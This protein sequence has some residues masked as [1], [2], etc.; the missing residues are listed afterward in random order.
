MK[1]KWDDNDYLFMLGL[2]FAA[3]LTFAITVLLTWEG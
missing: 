2:I 3:V 1:D